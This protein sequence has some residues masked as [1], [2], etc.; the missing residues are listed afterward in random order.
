MQL[1][2]G[3]AQRLFPRHT[4]EVRTGREECA[5]PALP[6]IVH[7]APHLSLHAIQTRCAAL[8]QRLE[9][10]LDLSAPATAGC[11]YFQSAPPEPTNARVR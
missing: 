8:L 10:S 11:Q 1:A 6:H 5:I 3:D 2:R 7:N 9:Q 4:I